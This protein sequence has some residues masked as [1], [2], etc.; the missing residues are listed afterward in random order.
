MKKK[1]SEDSFF[2][3]IIIILFFAIS[4]MFYL[5]HHID[6]I[7]AGYRI[8]EIKKEKKA[9]QEEI[10]QLKIRK[11]ELM[12]LDRVDEIARSKLGLVKVREDEIIVIN[13]AK[14]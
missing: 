13:H 8:E 9:L 1:S 3:Y 14:D 11:S 5:W 2:A 10:R 12:R 6:V 4:V 7:R